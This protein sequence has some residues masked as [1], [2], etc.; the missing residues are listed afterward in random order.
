MTPN[1]TSAAEIM[2]ARTGRRMEVSESFMDGWFMESNGNQT[3]FVPRVEGQFGRGTVL[4]HTRLRRYVGGFP[5]R[6]GSVRPLAF[7]A[8]S[9]ERRVG[10]E[11]RSRWSPYH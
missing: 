3:D 2:L 9:E 6:E 10:K 8:R 4:A 7:A 11:C 5:Q 1:R